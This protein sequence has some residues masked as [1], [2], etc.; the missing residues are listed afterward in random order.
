MIS[1]NQI[2]LVHVARNRLGMAEEDYRALLRREAGVDSAA[3]L[4]AAGLDAV[5]R[6]F[7]ALGFEPRT[8]AGDPPARGHNRASA[9]QIAAMRE[10][11]AA[12]I[13]RND[14]RALRTWLQKKFNVSHPRFLEAAEAGKA[15]AVLKRMAGQVQRDPAPRGPDKAA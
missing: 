5:M 11:F 3:E 9:Q 2:A 6:A 4:D 7:K 13:G 8:P 10:A 15:V 1:T 12:Y 14:D